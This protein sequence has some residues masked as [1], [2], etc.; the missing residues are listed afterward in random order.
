MSGNQAILRE[1]LV[2]LGYRVDEASTRKFDFSLFRTDLS[3]KGLAKTVLGVGLAVSGMTTLFARSMEQLY[4]AS[5]RAETGAGNLQAFEFAAKQVGLQGGVMTK[6]VEGMASAMRMNPGLQGLIESFGIQVTGRDKA[7][8]ALDLLDV[9]RRFPFYEGA[10]QAGLFGIGPDEYLLITE[11]LD[12]FREAAELR[13]QMAKDAG[14]DADAAARAG[15]EYMNSLRRIGEKLGLIKDQL[16]VSL[17]EPAQK[18][19]TIIE[20][21]LDAMTNWTRS[22]FGGLKEIASKAAA[23]GN[24]FSAWLS[25]TGDLSK[26]AWRWATGGNSDLVPKGRKVSGVVGSTGQV[27]GAAGAM[28]SQLEAQYGLPPG[29]LDRMWAK[30][31]ARGQNMGPSRAGALGHF[32]FMPDTARQYGIYGKEGDLAAS[33]SAAA[34]MMSD[35]LKW[36]G[37]DLA[38]ALAGYNWGMGNVDKFGMAKMPAETRDYI[39]TITGSPVVLQQTN[40][41]E[42][43][44]SNAEEVARRTASFQETANG[45]LVRNL[46]GVIR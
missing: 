8:V 30:E 31:S 15:K 10:L 19:L 24:P 22:N 23:T 38:K 44:G 33:A 13:K 18:F 45:D 43:N 14:V 28:F 40:T 5:R 20:Q 46:A 11:S 27:S 9:L 39:Q 34:R 3:V 16:L 37:G 7:D 32:Q 35:L 42:V 21:A 29:L 17:V 26:W 12:K 2:S 41:F 1:Y 6:V 36:S 25:I 4:Y